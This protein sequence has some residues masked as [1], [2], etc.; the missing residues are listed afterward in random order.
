MVLAAP[1]Q[2]NSPAVPIWLAFC[3]PPFTE[4]PSPKPVP[5]NETSANIPTECSTRSPPPGR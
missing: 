1:P 5:S 3:G 4:K 2:A